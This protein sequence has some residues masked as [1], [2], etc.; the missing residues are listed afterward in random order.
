MCSLLDR[1]TAILKQFLNLIIDTR[2]FENDNQYTI[3]Y[4]AHIHNE[5]H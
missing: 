1:F 2:D 3:L 5:H 4:C